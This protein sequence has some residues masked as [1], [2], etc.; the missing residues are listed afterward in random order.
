MK[1][2]FILFA[3]TGFSLLPPLAQSIRE[4]QALLSDARLYQSLGSA[5]VIQEITRVGD[6]YWLRTEHYAMKVLL[7]YGGREERM[8]GPIH[9]ELEFQAPVELSF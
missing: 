1:W 4:L 8:M 6:G 5:E 7:K 2:L 9:F 3:A